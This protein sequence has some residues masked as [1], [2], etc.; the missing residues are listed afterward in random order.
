[1]TGFLHHIDLTVSDID[2]ARPL[3]DLFLTHAGFTSKG[4]GEEWAGWGLGDNRYPCVT[5]NEAH[6]PNAPRRHDRYSAGLHHLALRAKNCA[7]VDALHAKLV[8]IG[9]NILDAPSEYPD[10]GAGYY[11]VFFA[12][13]DGIKLEY[14][15]TPPEAEVRVAHG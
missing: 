12:D 15:F 4:H 6:G 14:V 3:Y 10:Y 9:A 1:M 8:A 2:A 11:A 7:D 5:L 13:P